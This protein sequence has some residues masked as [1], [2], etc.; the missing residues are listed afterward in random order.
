MLRGEIK[1]PLRLA[2]RRCEYKYILLN[3]KGEAAYEELVEFKPSH[4]S[5]MNRCLVIEKGYAAEKSK[6]KPI[7]IKI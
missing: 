6:L 4:V 7:Y 2:S 3:K 5:I 1:V